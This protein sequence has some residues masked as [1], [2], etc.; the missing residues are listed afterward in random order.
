MMTGRGRYQVVL[1]RR[2]DAPISTFCL[3]LQRTADKNLLAE[4]YQSPPFDNSTP[5][6]LPNGV[7]FCEMV[8]NVVRSER[9]PL[10]GRVSGA[11]CRQPCPLCPAVPHTH[12]HPAAGS[13]PGTPGNGPGMEQVT[14]RHVV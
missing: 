11:P 4:L 9:R 7:D 10:T 13:C 14:G 3:L 1:N 12:T 8:G 6:E 5:N 2:N